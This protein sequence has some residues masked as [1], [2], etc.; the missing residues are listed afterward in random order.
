MNKAEYLA[1]LRH[2][3]K[4]LPKSE[5]ESAI[6]FYEEYF[7]DA[8][9]QNEQRV[10]AELG[11]PSKL[12]AKIIGEYAVSDTAAK[13]TGSTIWLVILSVFAAPIA[14]PIAI[15]VGAVLFALAITIGALCFSFVAVGFALGV[16]GLALIYVGF[17]MIFEHLGTA[18]FYVGTGLFCL[19]LGIFISIAILKVTKG[20]FGGLQ[21]LI[22]KFLVRRGSR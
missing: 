1:E 8:G 17:S 18:I 14:L 13:K 15:A 5:I 12:A 11:T 9:V 3:L 2:H 19:P 16:S 7:N 22:G 6:K 10:V 4:R 20:V 21:R